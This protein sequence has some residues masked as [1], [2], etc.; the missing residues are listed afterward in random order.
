MAKA[1]TLYYPPNLA[2]H[3]AHPAWIQFSFFN[4][5]SLKKSTDDDVIQLYMPETASSPNTVSWDAEKFGIVGSAVAGAYNSAA[6]GLPSAGEVVAGVSAKGMQIGQ[7]A[8]AIGQAKL[9]SAVA[10]KFGGHVSAE[11]LMGATQGRIMNPYLTMVFRGVD[12][13]S[14]ACNFS[15]FP[16]KE[17]DCETI[18]DI[19]TSFRANSLP[20]LQ[21]NDAFMGY[22][23]EVEIAYKW[24]SDDNKWLH[25]FKRCVLT[26][27]DTDYTPDGMFSVMRNGMPACIKVNLQ[28]KEIEIVMR[29]DVLEGGY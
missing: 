22:P 19:I 23:K 24:K 18:H 15:F 10:Q 26:S 8:V 9:L 5:K 13:R 17:S 28:F 25:K 27:V 29:K 2:D 14:F 4:R 7:A 6:S 16:F 1:K 12:F 11:G 20:D 3:N 21:D